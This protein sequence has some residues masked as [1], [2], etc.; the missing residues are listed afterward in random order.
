MGR[1]LCRIAAIVGHM[2]P[3]CDPVDRVTVIP[4]GQALG[5]TVRIGAIEVRSNG[6][7]PARSDDLAQNTCILSEWHD[8]VRKTGAFEIDQARGREMRVRFKSAPVA[9]ARPADT[10]SPKVRE[11]ADYVLAQRAGLAAQPIEVQASDTYVLPALEE[12]GLTIELTGYPLAAV[13]TF[14]HQGAVI[15]WTSHVVTARTDGGELA[16][17]DRVEIEDARWASM[18]ELTGPMA[19][20]LRRSGSPL[21][22]YRAELHDQIAA[23]GE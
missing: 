8:L 5:V 21:F 11:L 16:P 23:L 2:L 4:Q 18:A 22:A 1:K 10:A 19:K 20:V 3:S 7:I 12:T 14:T 9:K 13:S 6:L 17:R 15:P